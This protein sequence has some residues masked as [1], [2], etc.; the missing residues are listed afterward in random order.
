MNF[1][2]AVFL[3]ILISAWLDSSAAEE[4]KM[5]STGRDDPNILIFS[6]SHAPDGYVKKK[7]GVLKL[8]ITCF[9][10]IL[11]IDVDGT[12]F[13]VPART[14]AQIEVPYRIEG[15]G[16]S[17][18]VTVTTK[19]GRGQKEYSIRY[20]EKP[21]PGAAPF[22]LVAIL[23]G[24]NV[25]NLNN[26]P[27]SGAKVEAT[28]SA[29]TLVP[30]LSISIGKDSVLRIRSIILRE[31]YS[32]EDFQKLEISYT[33]LGVQ[34]IEKDTFM[35]RFTG[36]V[37]LNDIRTD[38][39]NLAIGEEETSTESY[40]DVGFRQKLGKSTSSNFGLRYVAK[41][42]TAEAADEDYETDAG[43]LT[44]KAGFRT[45][46]IGMTSRIS[47]MIGTNDAVGM[48]ED[49]SSENLGLK[50]SLRLGG[51]TPSLQYSHRRKTRSEADPATDIK[52]EDKSDQISLKFDYRLFSKT[53][54]AL[55]HKYK[56]QTSN[57][58]A[59][60]YQINT[61]ALSI[62]TVF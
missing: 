57:V 5:E 50:L 19:N 17:R 18:L 56:E 62:T 26:T 9:N 2:T 44:L 49:Y 22:Q 23:A 12:A 1:R 31:K 3:L 24:T 35:G 43:A 53:V 47:A 46:L 59:N 14:E 15:N 6:T 33:K 61:T 54:L 51:L 52:T 28:K 27:E 40:L 20:G 60:R 4:R 39:E 16:I 25:D 21:K 41:D 48:Y 13:E 29:V 8:H 45:V 55:T 30:Q 58:E 32:D 34:W 37:G 11:R 42:F 38:N 7:T 36:G 10:P